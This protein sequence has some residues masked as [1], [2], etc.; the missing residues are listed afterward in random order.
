MYN[1]TVCNYSTDNQVNV[2]RHEKQKKHLENT[3]NNELQLKLTEMEEK[4]KLLEIENKKL[5]QE[6]TNVVNTTHYRNIN[7]ESV[8]CIS[9]YLKGTPSLVHMMNYL[10]LLDIVMDLRVRILKY[11]I[12]FQ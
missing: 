4:Y 12:W 9:G 8:T 10:K 6:K 5:K 1:C 3:K 2:S 7:I 11:L